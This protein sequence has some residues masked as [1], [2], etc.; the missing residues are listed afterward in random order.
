MTPVDAISQVPTENENDTLE[1][2]IDRRLKVLL[3]TNDNP[4]EQLIVAMQYNDQETRNIA[5]T[6]K[7]QLDERIKQDY[8]LFNGLV[9]RRDG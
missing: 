6:F 1:D 5:D 8:E 9:Y 7:G 3:T 2:I 4:A